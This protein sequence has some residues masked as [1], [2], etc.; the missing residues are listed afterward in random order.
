MRGPLTAVVFALL[1]AGC[2]G[3]PDPE[4]TTTLAASA[5]EGVPAAPLGLAG[6]SC[7]EGGGHSVH[8]I[9][10]NPLPEPWI[11]ADVIGD[12]GEQ[13]VYSEVPDVS[14]PIPEEGT[15][16]GNWHVTV[17][18][19]GWTLDGEPKSD[20]IFGYVGMKVEAP[21]FDNASAPATHQY[22][23]TVIAT[24]DDDLLTRLQAAGYA[25]IKATAEKV[26]A[27]DGTLRVQMRTEGNG[28]YD[29]LFRPKEMGP[30]EATRI[31][32]WYQSTADGHGVH[33]HEP[34]GERRDR[35]RGEFRPIALDLVSTGG[36]RIAAQGQGYFS[37][38]GTEHHAPLPG[39]YGQT[40]AFGHV[41]FDRVFE[42]GPRPDVVLSE[43]YLH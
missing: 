23:V 14:N 35:A 25:A 13:L 2:T 1:A 24:N 4:D 42:W 3:A 17:I 11:P 31:R 37:H 8:P 22:L 28:E 10:F 39:A 27:P 16:M 41:G 15:T 30:L 38:S 6:T 9:A 36:T 20:L 34:S 43:A 29:S 40:A 21:P 5:G 18:C 33:G 12:V 26:V 32:I 19:E 7:W